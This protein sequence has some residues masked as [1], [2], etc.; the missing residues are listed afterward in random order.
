MKTVIEAAYG[1]HDYDL[2]FIGAMV[3]GNDPDGL[4]HVFGKSGALTS[5]AVARQGVHAAL[6]AGRSAP[7]VQDLN[8]Y[9]TE[10]SRR[11]LEEVPGIHI[12]F[13]RNGAFF[14]GEKVQTKD[15]GMNSDRFQFDSFIFK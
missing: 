10:V 14:D 13:S 5:P 6:E 8:P 11:I 4:Y 1:K 12:A 15:R 9:Y 3:V 7:R 2:N